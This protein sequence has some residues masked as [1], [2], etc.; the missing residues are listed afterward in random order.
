MKILTFRKPTQ[1][2]RSDSSEIGLTGYNVTS[3]VAWHFEL[4]VEC[5]LRTSKNS[6]EFIACIINIWVDIFHDTLESEFCLLSQT[7]SSSASGWLW[8]SNFADQVDET[9][10]LTTTRKLAYLLMKS[11]SSLYSQWL[12]DDQNSISDILFHDFHTPPSNLAFLP[13][14]P[15]IVSWLT[16]LLLSQPQKEP[17]SKEHM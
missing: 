16:C 15:D 7:E 13:E 4:P 17:W 5:R 2:Y 12:P 3:R 8:K 10:Q 1:V 9:I 11:E 6:L 14:S